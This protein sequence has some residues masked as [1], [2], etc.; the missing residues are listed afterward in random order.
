MIEPPLLGSAVT[1]DQWGR[2]R[3][4]KHVAFSYPQLLTA[5]KEDKLNIES[6]SRSLITKTR[7]GRWSKKIWPHDKQ[8]HT[9][10]LPLLTQEQLYST[11]ERNM[12]H[13]TPSSSFFSFFTFTHPSAGCLRGKGG[14]KKKM[15]ALV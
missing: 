12:P 2:V 15:F 13:R 11:A 4:P 6:A 7:E 10:P 9:A 1:E 3:G 5:P 8:H 14:N